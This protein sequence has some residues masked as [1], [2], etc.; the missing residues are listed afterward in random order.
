MT[1]AKPRVTL[2]YKIGKDKVSERPMIV[3]TDVEEPYAGIEISNL[4]KAYELALVLDLK[5]GKIPLTSLSIYLPSLLEKLSVDDV[6][7]L[8]R[9][10]NVYVDDQIKLEN[11]SKKK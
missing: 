11:T 7:L 9:A 3:G 4:P 6:K 1:K 10:F 5:G 2:W 8:Q